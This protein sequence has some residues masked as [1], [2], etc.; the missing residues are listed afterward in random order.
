M[1]RSTN[2]DAYCCLQ[3]LAPFRDA[4]LYVVADGMGGANAGEIASRLAVRVVVREVRSWLAARAGMD[5]GDPALVDDA[6]E[7][8]AGAVLVANREVFEASR[9]DPCRAGMGTTIT[10]ALFL[11]GRLNVAHVGDSRGFLVRRGQIHQIT[12]DHSLVAEL[13][14]NGGITEAE[15]MVH[16]Q[17][18]VLTRALGT[19]PLVAVDIWQEPLQSGDIMV[20]CSD[21]VTRHMSNDDLKRSVLAHDTPGDAAAALVSLGNRRGGADNLTVV[22]VFW[23]AGRWPARPGEPAG[24]GCGRTTGSDEVL[25]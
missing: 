10:A 17:R 12:I 11:A 15:A 14:R 18:N 3:P 16:P 9:L 8:L 1:V 21:G 5:D 23:R 2:E 13:V 20:L 19:E 24:L 6:P 25:S 22:V 7:A 4:G